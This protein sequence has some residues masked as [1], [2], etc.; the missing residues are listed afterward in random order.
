MLPR[1]AP[2]SANKKKANP[3]IPYHT[4]NTI[5]QWEAEK[6][7]DFLLAQ[8]LI[9]SQKLKGKDIPISV[10]KNKLTV[11]FDSGPCS[12]LQAVV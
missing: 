3:I 4:Q 6:S 10:H 11:G 9:I 12:P 8:I 1:Y 5:Q 2:K 7:P